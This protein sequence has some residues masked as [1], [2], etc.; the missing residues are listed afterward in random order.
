M[1]KQEYEERLAALKKQFE[2]DKNKLSVEFAKSNNPYKVG[3]IL[4]SGR[5]VI[6]RVEKISYRYSYDGT[7]YCVYSGTALKK[8]LTPRKVSPLTDVIC[9]Y[10]KIIN[11][12]N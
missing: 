11:K 1:T 8:D 3:D 10:D 2:K 12:L 6:I 7:P 5:G 9:Q 4:S